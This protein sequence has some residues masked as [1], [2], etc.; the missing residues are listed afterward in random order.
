M[1]CNTV[2]V[3]QTTER[4]F[5]RADQDNG[6]NIDSNGQKIHQL[7]MIQTLQGKDVDEAIQRERERDLRKINQDL[8]MVNEMFKY[9]LSSVPLSRYFTSLDCFYK[10]TFR[11]CWNDQKLDCARFQL[12]NQLLQITIQLLN[13]FEF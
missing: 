10:F 1:E 13:F 8:I 5:S 6:A 11:L 12:L 3:T 4:D 9:V 2:R 7:Q